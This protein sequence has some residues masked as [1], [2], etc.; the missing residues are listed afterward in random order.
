MAKSGVL[1]L[2]LNI[3]RVSATRIDAG[4]WFTFTLRIFSPKW[5]SFLDNIHLCALFY[6]QDLKCYSFSEILAPVVR[7]IEMLEIDG[8]EVPIYGGRVCGS[9]G[10]ITGNN[11]GLHSLYGLIVFYSQVLLFR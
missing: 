5:N 10:D 7:D 9:V 8:V 4:K 3:D 2:L 6:A 11:L 1:S